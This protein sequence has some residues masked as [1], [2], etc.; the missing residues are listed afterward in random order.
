MATKIAEYTVMSK[1]DQKAWGRKAMVTFS[2][3]NN[4]EK[5]FIATMYVDGK[6]EA[7]NLAHEQSAKPWN[8]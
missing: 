3:L 5:K 4:G 6:V 2:N 7:R 8:F 1:R